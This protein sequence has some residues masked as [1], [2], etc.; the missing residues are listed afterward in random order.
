MVVRCNQNFSESFFREPVLAGGPALPTGES[1]EPFVEADDITDV[2]VA[3]LTDGRHAGEM[4][5]LTGPRLLSFG[6]VAAERAQGTGR[7]I[8]HTGISGEGFVDFL[9]RN[10]LLGGSQ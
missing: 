8:R 2:A 10:H 1:V 9:E 5:E 6:D 7:E 4:S 3:A